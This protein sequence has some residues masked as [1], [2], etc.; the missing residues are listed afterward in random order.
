MDTDEDVALPQDGLVDVAGLQ[1][2]DGSVLVVD[3]CEH[4]DR[5]PLPAVLLGVRVYLRMA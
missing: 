1:C 2:L 5:A 3:D 4:L